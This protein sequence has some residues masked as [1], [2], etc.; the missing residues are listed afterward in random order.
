MIYWLSGR[1]VNFATWLIGCVN[2]LI[3]L[4]RWLI[5]CQVGWLILPL[6]W[7]DVWTGWLISRD[8]WLVSQSWILAALAAHTISFHPCDGRTDRWRD[9]Q[10]D[11]WTKLRWLRRDESS[12]CFR[13]TA[14]TR[15]ITTQSMQAISIMCTWTWLL[16]QV[17]YYD[18]H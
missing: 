13:A 14:L 9:R 17:F 16:K 3:D 12:S 11:R 18:H 8:D 6:G 15:N 2:W 5:S 10:T 1:F 7:L 4:T